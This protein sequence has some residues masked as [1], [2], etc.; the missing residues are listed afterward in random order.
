MSFLKRLTTVLIYLFVFTPSLIFSDAFAQKMSKR[1]ILDMEN[2]GHELFNL[3]SFY[4]ALPIYLL[5]DSI[6]PHD[7]HY[8]YPIGACYMNAFNEQK[9]LPYLETCLKTPD[10][11]PPELHYYVAKAYHLN[12]QFDDAIKHYQVFRG[13]LKKVKIHQELL[14][15]IERDIEMCTVG[16]EL[17]AHPI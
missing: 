17:I 11:F 8:A 14:K 2:E 13:K 5:L 12:H 4:K 15:R 7:P 6:T 1:Q 16:K 10:R 3:H 9:A